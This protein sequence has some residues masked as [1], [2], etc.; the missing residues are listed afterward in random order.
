MNEYGITPQG[1]VL[2]TLAVIDG[3]IDATLKAAFGNHIN[4]TPPSVYGQLKAEF[5]ER[6]DALWQLAEA[7]YDSQYPDSAEKISLDDSAALVA[8]KRLPALKSRVAGQV[9][10]GT[11]GT[12]IP[13]GTI[14]AVDGDPSAQF[15]TDEEVT[16]SGGTDEVDCT[17]AETGPTIANANTLTQIVTPVSGLTEV[18]NPDAAITGRD[19][20]TDA[21]LRL[22]RETSLQISTSGPLGGIAN[23]IKQLNEETDRA[24]I[25]AVLML[26]NTGSVTDADGLPPKSIC[27]VVYQA[28]NVDDRDQEIAQAIYNS[29]PAGIETYGNVSVTVTDSEGYEHI[30]KFSRPDPVNVYLILDLTVNALY[31]MDGD[32]QV[33]TA[34]LLYGSTL[35]VGDDVIVYPSLMAYLST[36]PGIT[37]VTVRIGTETGPTADDNIVIAPY[38]LSVWESSRITVNS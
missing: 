7:V 13:A 37:D 21:E 28:G 3:E 11:A 30:I 18:Y 33:E 36:I 31:P 2:K 25:E 8:V 32:G 5:A 16:L 17:A 6:E 27:A 35:S 24:T 20:E 22:R 19:I 14:F 38:E 4:T 1:F 23:A 9:L 26:E 15:L 10:V 12:V 34:M 29:K